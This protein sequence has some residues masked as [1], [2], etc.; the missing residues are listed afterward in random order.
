LEQI[1][2]DGLKNKSQRSSFW[3]YKCHKYFKKMLTGKNQYTDT[4]LVGFGKGANACTL[5]YCNHQFA[6]KQCAALLL[7]M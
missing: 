2:P 7:G 5:I 6:V 4:V 3:G 1:Y